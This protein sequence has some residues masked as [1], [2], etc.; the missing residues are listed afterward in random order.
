MTYEQALDFWFRRVNYEKTVPN[1]DD[2]K[3]DRMRELLARLGNPHER[4]RIV[5]VAGS[6]GKGSVSAMLAAILQRNGYRTGLFTSPHLC[7]VEERIQIDR[8][9]IAP[10]DLTALLADIRAAVEGRHAPAL[11]PTFFEIAT[12]LGFLHFARQQVDL[13]VIEV[14]LGGRFD[15]TNVCRPVVTAITSISH[16]HT[17]VLGHRLASI[18]MEK[19]GIIKPGCPAVS[20]ATAPE[21]RAV[22]EPICRERGAPLQQLEVD[23]RY[24]Y[25]PGRVI[26]QAPSFVL[27][28]P[29][30]QITTPTRT[31][32]EMEMSLLGHHQADNAAVVVACVE[33]LRK[34]GL[35]VKDDAVSAGLSAVQWP[36]RL[37]ILGG[38]PLVVLDCAHN[39][40]SIQ[41]FQDTLAA[42][43]PSGQRWLI[44]AGST[45]KDL[46]AMLHLL[47]PHFAHVFLTR[48][49]TNPR[50]AAPE[51]LAAML[52]TAGSVPFTLCPTALD[53]WRKA[54]TAAAPADLVC[55]T[56][57]VFLAGELRPAIAGS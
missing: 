6:K 48:Y 25:K 4:L 38:Q 43:F 1:A 52:G 15:S 13:A 45:D 40:A 3:L 30:V 32:P 49:G 22:I 2:L 5:H 7:R 29:R 36:A 53:A 33:Q 50:S 31:W 12:A 41:A 10:A 44:F 20:G 23:F 51:Q 18:A 9:P 28:K 26:P 24:R 47:A 21:A 54:R 11:A 42:S 17:D 27:H 35:H 34:L 14:G 39:V 57:S 56:G 8:T 46:P 55:V 19:A 16:D 37:E